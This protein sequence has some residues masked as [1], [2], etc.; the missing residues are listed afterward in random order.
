MNI[1]LSTSHEDHENHMKIIWFMTFRT[2]LLLLQ[3][4]WVLTLIKQMDLS[5]IYD[6][7][8]YVVLFGPEIYGEM[9][10]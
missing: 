6:E 1:I 10:D 2:K 3:N 9:Y 7:T 5:K 4:H 8:R